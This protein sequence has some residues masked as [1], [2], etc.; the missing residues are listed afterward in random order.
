MTEHENE[1]L[2]DLLRKKNE[3]LESILKTGNLTKIDM[4]ITTDQAEEGL[5][6]K[7]KLSCIDKLNDVQD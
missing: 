7:L 4:D 3:E 1:I 6:L 2:L 5:K